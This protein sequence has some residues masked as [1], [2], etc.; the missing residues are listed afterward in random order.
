MEIDH[1]TLS[2]KEAES[3]IEEG[4]DSIQCSTGTKLRVR[5]INDESYINLSPAGL[6][7]I[8]VNGYAIGGLFN[9]LA[10]VNVLGLITKSLGVNNVGSYFG[11]AIMVIEPV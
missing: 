4:K 8:S 1:G 10:G 2:I 7:Y 6:T 9:L 11:N 3:S 5:L